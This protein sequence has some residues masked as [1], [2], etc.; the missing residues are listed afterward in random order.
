M[1]RMTFKQYL[2]SKEQLRRAIERTPVVTT[3]YEVKKYCTLTVGDSL[4]DKVT[5]GL[6]PRNKIVV[7]WRYDNLLNPTPNFIRLEGVQDM[8]EDVQTFWT[9]QK[10]RSWL[11]R[12]TTE[13][14]HN[15]YK[16]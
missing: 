6:K 9:S 2:E 11:L 5:V 12:Y 14:Q 3:V 10:L 16:A 13:E 8:T 7:E 1:D 15:G 4:S